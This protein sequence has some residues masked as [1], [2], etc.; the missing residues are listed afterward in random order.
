MSRRV[1]TDYAGNELHPGDVVCYSA[2][3]GNRV[4]LTDAEIVKVTTRLLA[5]RLVPMLMVQPTGYESGFARR[6]S[7]RRVWIGAEHVR[8]VMPR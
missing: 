7:L 2:R 1:V 8:L 4:R 3:Q 6:R 5:G